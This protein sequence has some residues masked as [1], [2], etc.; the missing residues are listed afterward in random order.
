MRAGTRERIL[1]GL[2]KDEMRAQE[3]HG[4]PRSRAHRGKPQPLEQA[5]QDR[6]GCLAGM[7]DASGDA[8][9]PGR[10]GD[11][12]RVEAEAAGE[13]EIA[14]FACHAD[15]G[16]LDGPLY[17]GR[18]MGAQVVGDGVAILESEGLDKFVASWKELLADVEGALASARKAS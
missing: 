5:F 1:D 7:N 17:A 18:D 14:A 6:V 4:L 16:V 15:G 13:A 2:S 11:E 8:E 3:P 12:Q 9:R 10:G